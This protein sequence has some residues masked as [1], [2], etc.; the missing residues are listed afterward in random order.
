MPAL[1]KQ[2]FLWITLAVGVALAFSW[3][4]PQVGAPNERTRIYLSLSLLEGQVEVTDQV[5]R[6]GTPF[7]ISKR[8][9]AY[10]T[11]K[12]PGASA[13]A[14]PWVGAYRLIDEDASIEELN[15]FLRH[16]MMVPLTL[17]SF[18]LV[19]VV[20]VGAG[21]SASGANRAAILF[22]LGTNIFH[23]GGAFYGHV[24]VGLFALLAAHCVQRA[25]EAT[26]DRSQFL[27][28][29]AAGLAGAC[30]FAIEYQAAVI[31]IALAI[32]YLV[33]REHRQ[34]K[35]VLAP[36]L[37]ALIPIVPTMLYNKVA[38]GG[39]LATG[40]SHLP[41]QS[42]S[43]LHDEGL[44]GVGFP[45]LEALYGLLV[46]P[47]RGLLFCAPVVLVGLWGLGRVW[48]RCRWL[49]VY[50]AV[51]FA[52]YFYIASASEVWYAGWAFGPRLLIPAFGLAA[53]GAGFVLDE[54][55]HWLSTARGAVY[56][57]LAGGVVYNCFV[58]T[59]FPELP[60]KITAPLRTIAIPLAEMGAP[61]PNLGMTILGLSG[62]WSLL[63]LA[64]LAGGLLAYI[65]WPLWRSH[66]QPFR[67]AIAF[68]LALAI[69][70]LVVH[71]YPD[72]GKKGQNLAKRV[73][74][75]RVHPK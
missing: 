72:G 12:A 71:Q 14:V 56:G 35:A 63:P 29:F 4:S 58:V 2:N 38:F 43:Q 73:S 70:G 15:V 54:T 26:S 52:G 57:L 24:A 41:H 40:Y 32:A 3:M 65:T 25:L 50:I 61:S 34:I 67:N 28:R 20:A 59:M 22:A 5:E 74:T 45:T 18:L 10:F 19:R 6:F 30:T 31:C 53:I 49:A 9:G 37:G 46:S 13:L 16:W 11:D 75:Y 1:F 23:Y 47:S 42:A 36:A 7:D 66:A 44:Y 69:F 33:V 27:W 17:L 39:L 21:V 51:S 48:G 60:P 68:G 64:A 55:D 62:L 8:N